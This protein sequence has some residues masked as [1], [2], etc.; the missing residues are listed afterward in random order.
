M[1]SS[2]NTAVTNGGVEHF[3]YDDKIVRMFAI[4]TVIWALVGMLV[5]VIIAS[6]LVY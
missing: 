6:Q 5:G 2:S 3:S 4:A 1:S